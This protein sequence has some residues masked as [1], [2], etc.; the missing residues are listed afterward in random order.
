MGAV[1]SDKDSRKLFYFITLNFSF[2]LLQSFYG[3]VTGSLGLIS[4]SIHMLFDCLAMLLGLAATVLSKS[5]PNQRFPYGF[6]KMDTVAGFGNGVFLI[7]ISIEIIVE[8][9][10]RLFTG[11]EINRIGELLIVSSLGLLVNLVGIFVIGH[12]HAGHSH[13]HSHAHPPSSH[14]AS[15]E[16]PVPSTHGRTASILSAAIPS[17]L[18]PAFNSMPSSPFPFL[19]ENNSPLP[20]FSTSSPKPDHRPNGHAQKH[21]HA[22]DSPPAACSHSHSHHGHH[23]HSDNMLGIYLHIL[24]DTMGSVAVIISTL[25]IHYF[26]WPGFDPIASCIIAILILLSALPLIRSSGRTLLLSIPA[27][28][29]YSLRDTLQ[30]VSG[31]RGVDQCTAPRFWMNEMEGSPEADPHDYR[32]KLTTARAS[33]LGVLH[34]KATRGA[35]IEDVRGRVRAFLGMRDMDL[36]VQVEGEGGNHCWCGTGK[37]AG[38]VTMTTPAH[39]SPVRPVKRRD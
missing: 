19:S 16:K 30:G 6:G 9:V 5:P 10:E 33:V 11:A 21:D 35:R 13:G 1:L 8:A 3:F 27:S 17:S 29:E 18:Q 2:M 39:F 14:D 38:S 36:T 15:P 12:Q 37:T 24:A 25:L 20:Q 7:L 31:L 28:T 22:L 32:G 34:V 4:D 26:G 23:D